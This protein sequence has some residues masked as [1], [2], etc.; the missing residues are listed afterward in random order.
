M[1]QESRIYRSLVENMLDAFAY[2]K[3]ILDDEENP[4]DFEFIEINTAFEKMTNLKKENILGKKVTEVLPGILDCNFNWLG[5]YKYE[6][7]NYTREST[8]FE[9]CSEYLNRWYKVINY[10]DKPGYFIAVFY[11]ITDHKK[12]EKKV[13]ES[14]QFLQQIIDNMF[15]LVSLTDMKGNFKFLGKSH[16]ILGYDINSLIGRNVL[17]FVHPDDLSKVSSAFKAFLANQQW[18]DSG[19]VEYRYLCADSNYLWLETIGKII[20]DE[21][22]N[23]KEILFSTRDVTQRKQVEKSLQ[24]SEAFIKSVMDNLPIGIAVNSVDPTVKFEYMN[25]NFIKY[26]RTTREALTNSDSFWDEVYEDAEFRKKLKKR[27]LDDC[28][29][30][31]PKRMRWE[32]IQ[33]ARKGQED[34]YITAMNIPI[35]D[36][37]L[38]ISTVWD[39]TQRKLY[40]EELQKSEQNLSITLQSIGDG[41]IATDSNEYIT[42]MNKQAEKL[43]GWTCEE[44]QGRPLIEIFN[45]I[46]EKTG[47]ALVN[48][49]NSVIKTGNIESLAN[50]TILIAKDGTRRQIAD[51]AAPIRDSGGTVI[52]AVMVFSDVTEKYKARQ[53]LRESEER[54]RSFVENASDIIYTL[55]E[56]GTFT[57]VS[58]NWK[59]L[60]GHDVSE[61][62]GQ[63]FTSFVPEED[64]E[65]CFQFLRKVLKEGQLT[66]S[67]EYRVRNKAGN[68]R[69]HSSK[70]STIE[71]DGEFIFIGV[72]R[73]ITEQKQVEEALMLER[74]RFSM[75][76]ET[77]PGYI[78]LQSPDYTV[79]YANQY[80]IQHFG[81]PKDR[82]CYEIFFGRS[83]PC[84]VCHTFKV[85]ATKAPHI[86]EWCHTPLGRTYVIYDYPF[87][88]SDGAELVLEIG[89]DITEHKQSEEK[90]RYTSLHDSLTGLYNRSYLEQE[91]QSL[92]TERQL[93]ISIIMAD[94][95]GLKLINDTYGHSVGD[96][97]LRHTAEILKKT[98]RKEDV[99]SRWSGDEFVVLLPKT[100][101]IESQVICKRIVDECRIT[102]VKTI[103]L[104]M[105][106]GTAS[107]NSLGK[108][109]TD[110]LK[111]AENNM[112]KHKLSESRSTKSA[113]LNALLKTLEEKSYETEGH[114][115]RMQQ[116]AM[117]VGEKINLPETELDR[118]T[119][120]VYLHD[121]GK[122][123][124]PE[125]VLTKKERLTKKDWEHIKKHP[126]SG[127]R[128][129][130]SMEEFA[131]IAEDIL[132]HHERWDGLG[133][134]EGLKEK[135]IPLLARILA[136]VD[137]Y[138]VMINGRPY[139]APLLK[140]QVV[141]EL[142]RCAGTQFD[143]ELVKVFL[144]IIEA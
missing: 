31:D 56:D 98:C 69:W 28:S 37:P 142:K 83:Q 23:P 94:L 120:L 119:L 18:Q 68:L 77:F 35:P 4:V 88:D 49:V 129:A 17:D 107:K 90:I 65:L 110:V 72:A 21:K 26:Y 50:D 104:S 53:E 42:R 24:Q 5:E 7:V 29:T 111:E 105:A 87:I 93:P 9:E 91:M 3:E 100:N 117:K 54:F 63:P 32:N 74:R 47:E 12:A 108:D 8:R 95:N 136:I 114:V 97:M 102:D 30:G 113:V 84:E 43:T 36:K 139:K 126:E 141:D 80:F 59:Y 76:L 86:R 123:T 89:L 16:K 22:G 44:A 106:L 13:Q 34:F 109:L 132:R 60:L 133:Y 81:D 66:E 25:D 62:E 85:F 135:E 61:I 116:I 71:K 11:D 125:E 41:V 51:S 127:Y 15:D 137:A 118:L 99:I 1:C 131:H 64:A 67:V 144:S 10:S 138:E 27:V 112:Y 14:E 128:I 19:K 115:Q 143:P 130:R 82:F 101:I 39:V 58:P 48:P 38:M 103:P 20:L 124:V 57:Y 55:R 33:V 40:E 78:Y 75:L 134:P 92:D 140:N 2:F 6:N 96:E 73:D 79:R 52:G 70:G 46:R 45:I 122:I 121:I